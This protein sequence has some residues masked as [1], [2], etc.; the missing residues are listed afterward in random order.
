MFYKAWLKNSTKEGK[1]QIEEEHAEEAIG[2]AINQIA[3]GTIV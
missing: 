1:K 3:G 2:D